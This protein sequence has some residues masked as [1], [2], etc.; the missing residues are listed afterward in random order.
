MGKQYTFSALGLD[1]KATGRFK[2]KIMEKENIK[3]LYHGRLSPSSLLKNNQYSSPQEKDS[4]RKPQSLIH[5][6]TYGRIMILTLL[7]KAVICQG[8]NMDFFE[9][10]TLTV[11]YDMTSYRQLANSKEAGISR[12]IKAVKAFISE[13]NKI[14]LV[15]TGRGDDKLK[16]GLI[17]ERAVSLSF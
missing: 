10:N 8:H 3:R 6:K 7:D 17:L 5:I 14:I 2:N 16:R 15:A 13:S 12:E 9:G 1:R 4:F 11:W